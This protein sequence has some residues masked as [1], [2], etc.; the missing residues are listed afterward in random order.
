MTRNLAVDI[1]RRHAPEPA[2]PTAVIFLAQPAPEPLPDEAQSIAERVDGVRAALWQIPVEQRRA[3]IL[4]AFHGYTA[5][6]IGE[7]EAIPLGTAK[8]RIRSGLI[9]MRALLR[10]D[11]TPIRPRTSCVV[12]QAGTEG[13][14]KLAEQVTSP[15]RTTTNKGASS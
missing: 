14:R 4:A 2:D 3:L 6:E 12:P 8:T 7:T 11:G 13:T 15:N 5:R 1:L 10:E 9:K